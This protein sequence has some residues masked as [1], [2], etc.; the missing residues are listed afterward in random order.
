MEAP[1]HPSTFETSVRK[2]TVYGNLTGHSRRRDRG[3][4]LLGKLIM[5]L[6]SLGSYI[7]LDTLFQ[8]RGMC[9]GGPT[10]T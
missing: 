10:K 3:D 4:L 7:P 5:Y 8:K 6:V 1:L 9:P 2:L